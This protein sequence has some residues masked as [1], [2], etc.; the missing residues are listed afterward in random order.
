MPQTIGSIIPVA[1]WRWAQAGVPTPELGNEVD[2]EARIGD[3][4][5]SAAEVPP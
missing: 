5:L 3:Q 4:T 1:A 2:L